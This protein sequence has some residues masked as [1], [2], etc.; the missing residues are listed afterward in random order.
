MYQLCTVGDLL[1]SYLCLPAQAVQLL[2]LVSTIDQAQKLVNACCYLWG[3][4]MSSVVKLY[5]D[6]TKAQSF[7]K[8]VSHGEFRTVIEH[9]ICTVL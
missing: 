9:D 6:L 5:Q 2:I 7:Q 3:T 1:P 4:S 8:V